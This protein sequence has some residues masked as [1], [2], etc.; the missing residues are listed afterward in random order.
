MACPRVGPE[1]MSGFRDLPLS[2]TPIGAPDFS[3]SNRLCTEM[4]VEVPITEFK[5]EPLDSSSNPGNS[6]VKEEPDSLYVPYLYD[7][8]YQHRLRLLLEIKCK[9]VWFFLLC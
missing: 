2:P 9:I 3:P 5:V 1:T 6:V 7:M 8:I 4:E